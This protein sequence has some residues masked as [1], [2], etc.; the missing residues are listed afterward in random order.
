MADPQD[1]L[2][3]IGVLGN[4]WLNSSQDFINSP[5]KG[6]MNNLR[7]YDRT[8]SP[9]E[10]QQVYVLEGSPRITSQPQGGVGYWGAAISFQVRAASP[11][12]PAYQWFKDGFAISWATNSTLTLTNLD[13]TDGGYYSVVV[14]N[15]V[16]SVASAPALVVVNPAGVSL[17]LYA[18][19]TINGTVGKNFGIQYT[20]DLAATDSWT[21]ITN[22]ILTQP[23]QLWMDTAVTVTSQ[24]RRFYRVIPIP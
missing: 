18:A 5:Y 11:F 13:L 9:S 7:F 6:A 17:G 2:P 21:T 12:S 24:P 16:A 20:T 22:I 3:R 14:S 8:L 1:S 19:L 10:V 4:D 15:S 23:A